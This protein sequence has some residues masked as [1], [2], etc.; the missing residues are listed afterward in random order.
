MDR[1]S[2]RIVALCFCVFTVCV[3]V[4]IICLQTK[5]IKEIAKKAQAL[6]KVNTKR[7]RIVV[8][9]QG[10]DDTITQSMIFYFVVSVL[11]FPSVSLFPVDN[12]LSRVCSGDKTETF[13]VLKIDPKDIVDTNG[14]GD[15]FVGG[16]CFPFSCGLCGIF[17]GFLSEFPA[18]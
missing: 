13:P 16:A 8:F 12:V 14:A 17:Y 6:P 10:K 11:C 7:S 2:L 9:T 5:D 3:D 1:L 15:A 4:Y 18:L